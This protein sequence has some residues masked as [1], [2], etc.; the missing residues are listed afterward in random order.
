MAA[1]AVLGLFTACTTAR[2]HNP[3]GTPLAPG[4]TVVPAVA[5]I[6]SGSTLLNSISGNFNNGAGLTGTYTT[7]V[8]LD[9]VSHEIDITYQVTNSASSTDVIEHV[10]GGD[11][12]NFLTNVATTANGGTAAPVNV[13]RSNIGPGRTIS[14]NFPAGSPDQSIQPGQMSNELIV[15]TNGSSY[16]TGTVGIIDSGGTTVAGFAPSAVPEPATMAM[17]LTVLPALALARKLRR[18]SGTA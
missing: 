17:A 5:G 11:Y 9:S 13:N 4:T 15:Y 6:P 2:A 12:S 18:K 8:Y 16:T 1:A 14:F 7:N 3:A 10:T